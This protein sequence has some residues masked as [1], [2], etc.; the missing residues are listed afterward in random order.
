MAVTGSVLAAELIVGAAARPVAAAD[1]DSGWRRPVDGGV[2]RAFAE[3]AGEYGPGH[4]GV[5]LAAAPG[6]A[7]RAAGA[8]TVTFAGDVAGALHVVVTHRNGLR[9]SYSF[10]VDVSVIEGD[11]VTNAT[12]VGHAGGTDAESAHGTGVVHFGLRVGERYV[13]PLQLFHTRDLRDLV[14]LVPAEGPL[15]ESWAHAR[16]DETATLPLGWQ[17]T[18]GSE[19]SNDDGCSSG[20]PI[21]GAAI[22]A[23]CDGVDW[24]AS[25]TRGRARYRPGGA[26]ECEPAGARVG[27]GVAGSAP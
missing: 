9:T 27:R 10:L 2:V 12:V 5:D 22:D 25:R 13:D 23:V 26:R 21:V 18:G 15:A 8:G 14:R 16:L 17:P 7:V 11:V 24:T 1:S 6:T 4:R 19:R 3:P 20:V